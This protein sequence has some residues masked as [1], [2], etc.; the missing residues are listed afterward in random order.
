MSILKKVF[1]LVKGVEERDETFL[2]H[3]FE[4]KDEVDAVLNKLKYTR[5]LDHYW[6][7]E[8]M[9]PTEVKFGTYTSDVVYVGVRPNGEKVVLSSDNVDDVVDDPTIKWSTVPFEEFK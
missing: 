6:V 2:V 1:G 5:P 3:T 4:S 9:S 7:E 8:L